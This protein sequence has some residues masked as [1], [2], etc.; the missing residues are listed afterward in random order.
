MTRRVRSVLWIVTIIA[1]V[2]GSLLLANVEAEQGSEDNADAR[3]HRSAGW[4][5]VG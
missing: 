2:A 5:V 4:F 3:S 1:L